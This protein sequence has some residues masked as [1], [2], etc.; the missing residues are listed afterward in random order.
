MFWSFF[1]SVI[2]GF[3][4]PKVYF[5][6]MAARITGPLKILCTSNGC[7]FAVELLF[8]AGAAYA[9]SLFCIALFRLWRVLPMT[10]IHDMDEGRRRLIFIVLMLVIP[11]FVYV[12][13]V[14]LAR[15]PITKGLLYMKEIAPHLNGLDE[16]KDQLVIYHNLENNDFWIKVIYYL[17]IVTVFGI[18][19]LSPICLIIIGLMTYNSR[20]RMSTLRY[21]MSM[22]LFK[23]LIIQVVLAFSMLAFPLIVGIIFAKLEFSFSDD[24]IQIAGIIASTHSLAEFTTIL[25]TIRPYRK[26]FISIFTN[27]F[28]KFQ[29]YLP[30]NLRHSRVSFQSNSNGIY[31]LSSINSSN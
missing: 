28:Q 12:S 25:C 5:P 31:S 30:E 1:F 23:T 2:V 7:H 26:H 3:M 8:F 27:I 29:K 20:K 17:L 14:V 15:V 22:M 16:F 24:I 11:C 6:Y 10:L 9:Q 18:I 4:R 19:T 13:P 21:K